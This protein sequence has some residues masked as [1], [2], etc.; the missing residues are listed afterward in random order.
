MNEKK[1]AADSYS[2][3]CI[4]HFFYPVHPVI[5]S[6]R[7]AGLFGN[8]VRRSKRNAATSS[9]GISFLPVLIL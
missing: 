6:P 5:F 2:S 9:R 8:F 4:L 1:G 7:A 3:L